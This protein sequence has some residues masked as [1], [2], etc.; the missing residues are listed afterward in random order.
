MYFQSVAVERKEETRILSL[1]A[2]CSSGSALAADGISHVLDLRTVKSLDK[3]AI[4][5]AV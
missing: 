5:E 2:F 1:W 4:T 3:D